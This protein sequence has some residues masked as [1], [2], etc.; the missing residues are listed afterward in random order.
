[1]DPNLGGEVIATQ[2]MNEFSKDLI[3]EAIAEAGKAILRASNAYEEAF[4]QHKKEDA[5]LELKPEIE[6]ESIAVYL[7]KFYKNDIKAAI[8]QMTKSE[9]AG[10]LNKIAKQI[11]TDSVDRKSVV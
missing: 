5:Q 1:M 11:L 9:R 7:D 10:E 2:D 8:N 6:N 4:S 3:V